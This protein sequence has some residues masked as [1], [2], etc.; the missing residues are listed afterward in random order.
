MKVLREEGAYAQLAVVGNGL[1]IILFDVVREVVD[2]NVV[3]LNVLHDLRRT[4]SARQLQ[5]IS[6]EK[7]VHE[8]V[9]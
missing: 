7:E 3:V 5:P 2:W 4:K 6:A 9:S 1:F 8:L